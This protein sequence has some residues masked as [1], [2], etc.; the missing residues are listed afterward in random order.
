MAFVL[1]LFEDLKN[2]VVVGDA[3]RIE[4]RTVRQ[5]RK[6]SP[7]RTDA[8]RRLPGQSNANGLLFLRR[9]AFNEFDYLRSDCAHEHIFAEFRQDVKW[10]NIPVCAPDK[11]CLDSHSAHSVILSKVRNPWLNRSLVTP[12]LPLRSLRCLLLKNSQAAFFTVEYSVLR[13]PPAFCY[14]ASLAAPA[15]AR[16]AKP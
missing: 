1:N 14:G 11:P 5:A 4:V 9:P 7:L 2:G 6:L 8:D 12:A 3:G 10:F 15:L 16:A 13:M